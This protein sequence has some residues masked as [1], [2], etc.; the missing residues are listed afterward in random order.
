MTRG[1]MIRN[2][3]MP[4]ATTLAKITERH[5]GCQQNGERKRERNQGK[6]RV[7][8]ELGK[9]LNLQSFPYHFVDISPQELHHE[10]EE[11]DEECPCKKQEETLEDKYI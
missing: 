4:A 7:K 1:R 6:C 11:A 9:D 3:G 10:D 5:Q 2:K 8:E